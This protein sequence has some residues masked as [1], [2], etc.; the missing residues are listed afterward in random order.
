[1]LRAGGLFVV[2]VAVN[3]YAARYATESE[4]N[5]VT[6]IILSHLPVFDVGGIFAY[7]VLALAFTVAVVILL[8]PQSIPFVLASLAVFILIRSLFITL[9]HIGPFP[10]HATYDSLPIAGRLFLF[11]GDLFFSGHT[12]IPFLM[13]LISWQT[14]A[15]RYSFVCW[16]ILFAATSLLGHY[17]YT[18]DV[19]SAYFITYAIHHINIW[20]FPKEY[21]VFRGRTWRASAPCKDKSAC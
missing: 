9:T 15:L 7:G 8:R 6:D 12:G 16:S 13:A 17:H 21:A 4:S 14:R 10:Q 1:M 3:F 19:L 18:I 11:G 2:S 20:L 5:P